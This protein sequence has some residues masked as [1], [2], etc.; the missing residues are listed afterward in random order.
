[1]N[2][3]DGS[4]KHL[5]F[6]INLA[7]KQKI[8]NLIIIVLYVQLE[9]SFLL[10]SL[11]IQQSPLQRM[12]LIRKDRVLLNHQNQ[13]PNHNPN[14]LSLNSFSF[15]ESHQSTTLPFPALL[16][17]AVLPFLPSPS[18]IPLPYTPSALFL[19]ISPSPFFTFAMLSSS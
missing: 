12:N 2:W 9:F 5:G 8:Y 6:D 10:C 17:I 1:M 14:G 15:C 16:S 19:P 3:A 18:T 11:F 13:F 4:E 7:C